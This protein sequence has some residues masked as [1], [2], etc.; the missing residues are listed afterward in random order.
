MDIG[1]LARTDGNEIK[2]I[3]KKVIVVTRDLTLAAGTQAVT[4]V[5]FKPKAMVF[6][7]LVSNAKSRLLLVCQRKKVVGYKKHFLID[8]VL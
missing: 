6:F 8:F 5:G 2:T 3:S 1:V 7:S 4:G